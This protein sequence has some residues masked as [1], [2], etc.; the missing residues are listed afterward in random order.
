MRATSLKKYVQRIYK[1]KEIW[2]KKAQVA[3][4]PFKEEWKCVSVPSKV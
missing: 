1:F 4:N 3:E 2:Q